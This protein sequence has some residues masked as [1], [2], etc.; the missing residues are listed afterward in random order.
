MPSAK[1]PR[2]TDPRRRSATAPPVEVTVESLGARGDGVATRDGEALFIPLALPGERVRVRP[3]A[4]RGEGRAAA[5]EAILTPA[6]E[7]VE[8][9]C[10]HVGACG[11]CQLQH[12]APQAMAAWKQA[13]VTQALERR[14]FSPA[15]LAAVVAPAVVLPPGTRRRATFA[16]TGRGAGAEI[17]F[18]ARGSHK[19]VALRTC[20]L[21]TAALWALVDPLRGLIRTLPLPRQGGDVAVTLT[22]TGADVVIDLGDDPD[23]AARERLAAFAEAHDLA[24]LTLRVGGAAPETAALRRL[25]QVT[26]G[27]V[28]VPLPAGGF[29]QPSRDGEAAL[30]ARV[31]AAVDTAA[32]GPVADLFGGIGTF[33]LP[34]RAA[35]RTVHVAEGAAEAVGALSGL[36]LDGLTAERR[37]LFEHPLAGRELKR[38]AA[39]VFDPP[40]AGARAQ[41]EALAEAGP[42][43][44]VAVSCNPATFARDARILVDGGYALET[45]TPVDQFPWSAH[46]EVTAVFRR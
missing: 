41:A 34:L 27:G 30:V 7:R 20:L 15:T 12:M 6:P 39:V 9:P 17:G 23:L 19:V 11:G 33:A 8:P 28:S 26:L 2:R 29:L 40:R 1:R 35:G 46:V 42:P 43:V 3:G 18:N 44:V 21:P 32:E 10:P 24:R 5:L 14:G 13:Q 4:P 31:Q 22:D 16:I 37:D 45:V 38:F 25:P 36:G